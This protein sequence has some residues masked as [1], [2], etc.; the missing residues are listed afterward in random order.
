MV[1]KNLLRI[2]VSYKFHLITIIFF[3][4]LY[5]IKGYKGNRFNFSKNEFL[6]DNI[7]CP[8]YFL[9]KIKKALE[10][11]NFFK[12]LDLGCGSGRTIDFFN[13]NFSNKNFV[14]IEH[15]SN[16]YNYCRKIFQNYP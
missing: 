6:A 12:F 3:E 1:L 5:L 13:K 15:F 8:Y 4:L 9:L 11:N 10:K 2:V 14:G 16:Q 7:P